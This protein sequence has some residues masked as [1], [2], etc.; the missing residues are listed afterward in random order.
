MAVTT[1]MS[2]N[3]FGGMRLHLNTIVSACGIQVLLG[4]YLRLILNIKWK[5][6][7]PTWL[8]TRFTTPSI[9]GMKDVLRGTCSIGRLF[10]LRLIKV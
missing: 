8:S 10:L 1:K 6:F 4:M 3:T 9:V 5:C 2:G 7:V